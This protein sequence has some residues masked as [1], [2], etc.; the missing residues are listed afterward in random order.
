MRVPLAAGVG[1]Y[2][3]VQVSDELQ[4]VPAETVIASVSDEHIDAGT[5]GVDRI[6]AGTRGVDGRGA[7]AASFVILPS[8]T[9]LL[10]AGKEPAE[11]AETAVA[12]AGNS[13]IFSGVTAMIA[14]IGLLIAGIPFLGLMGVTQAACPQAAAA[15]LVPWKYER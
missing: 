7:D 2:W 6:A 3:L 12:T 1:R 8:T 10:A 4:L 9:P 5:R 13:V 14:L 15:R 11:S